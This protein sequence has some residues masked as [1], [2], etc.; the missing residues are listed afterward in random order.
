M[1]FGPA[2][3]TVTVI[4]IDTNFIVYVLAINAVITIVVFAVTVHVVWC[5]IE[6]II[7]FKC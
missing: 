2:D 1:W 7:I 5:G 6:G 4:S 3:G